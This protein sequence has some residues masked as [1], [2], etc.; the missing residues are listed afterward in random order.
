[1]KPKTL[2]IVDD[3]KKV[4]RALERVFRKENY[5]IHCIASPTKALDL[6]EEINPQVVLSD[7]RMPHMDGLDFLTRVK[8]KHPQCHCILMTGDPHIPE[9]INSALGKGRIDLFVEKTIDNEAL[10]DI[11]EKAFEKRMKK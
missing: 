7:R 4:L 2:L 1:M 6:I 9:S 5:K 10:A 3:E 11:I 8:E